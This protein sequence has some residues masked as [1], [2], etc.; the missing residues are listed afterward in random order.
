MGYTLQTAW[1]QI[2][3]PKIRYKSIAI[4]K[5]GFIDLPFYGGHKSAHYPN[6]GL[7]LAY[8]FCFPITFYNTLENQIDFIQV[9]SVCSCI[10]IG[11][12]FLLAALVA[13]SGFHKGSHFKAIGE[14]RKYIILQLLQDIHSVK[15]CDA[16]K[17]V[18]TAY[19]VPATEE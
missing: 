19:F 4:Q 10:L 7:N 1:K 16:R 9:L 15:I 13:G 8:N 18:G 11:S 5:L 12:D 6:F 3:N 17:Y 2:V 14:T